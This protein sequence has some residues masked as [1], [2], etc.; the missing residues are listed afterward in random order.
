MTWLEFTLTVSPCMS[1]SM[2]P[3]LKLAEAYKSPITVMRMEAFRKIIGK[4]PPEVACHFSGFSECTLNYLWSDMLRHASDAG[5]EIELYT[6]LAGFTEAQIFSVKVS[7]IKYI[8]LHLPDETGFKFNTDGWLKRF[9][10][11]LQTGH[12][13]SPMAMTDKVDPRIVAAVEMEGVKIEY[14]GMLSR[15]GNLWDIPKITGKVGC[16]VDRWH[17]NVTLPDSRVFGDCMDYGL[18]VPLGDLATQPYSEIYDAAEAWKNNDHSDDL[19]A[20]CEWR[21]VT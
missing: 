7:K 15:G 8:R 19:C 3:Q 20:R 5:R 2:C 18:T 9:R 1:C 21:S 16:G 14:P 4:L 12:P 6:T 11:F 10:W 17:C 13:F